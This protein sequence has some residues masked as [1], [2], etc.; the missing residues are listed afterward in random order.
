MTVQE[1]ILAIQLLEM[2]KKDFAYADKI[3][4][5]GR[6]VTKEDKKDDR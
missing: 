2:I 6:M 4:I 3:G 5:E 1:R